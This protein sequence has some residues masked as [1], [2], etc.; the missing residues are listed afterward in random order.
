MFLISWKFSRAWRLTTIS[1][2]THIS[3]VVVEVTPPNAVDTVAVAA[4]ILV[5]KT[6][7]L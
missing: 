1:L 3:A 6:G 7:V 2:V 5:A 4:P